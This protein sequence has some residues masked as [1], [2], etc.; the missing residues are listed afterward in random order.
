L[1][2][3]VLLLAALMSEPALGS[4]IYTY[5]GTDYEAITGSFYFPGTP[6]TSL[7]NLVVS[8]SIPTAIAPSSEY[9]FTAPGSTVENPSLLGWNSFDGAYSTNSSDAQDSPFL[10][11]SVSTDASGNISSWVFTVGMVTPVEPGQVQTAVSESSCSI[12]M[13]CSSLEYVQI[14]IGQYDYEAATS[15]TPGAWTSQAPTPEPHFFWLLALGGASLVL[16]KA[17]QRSHSSAMLAT[18]SPLGAN[19]T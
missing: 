7:D 15:G 4:V 12:G 8:F 10:Y 9:L 19:F 18:R 17:R 1:A 3:G 2:A 11:G 6:L 14:N 5:T 13:M 16:I